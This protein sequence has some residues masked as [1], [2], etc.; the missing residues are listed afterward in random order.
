[1]SY[2]Y[3]NKNITEQDTS[4]IE[5][6]KQEENIYIRM[7]KRMHTYLEPHGGRWREKERE[8]MVVWKM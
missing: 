2:N 8:P 4:Y 1:M 7:K 5:V 3:H 6:K